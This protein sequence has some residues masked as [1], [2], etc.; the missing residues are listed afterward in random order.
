MKKIE[1]TI[2]LTGAAQAEYIRQRW[3]A[4]VVTEQPTLYTRGNVHGYTE[5]LELIEAA[6]DTLEPDVKA[7]RE[8]LEVFI[9][10]ADLL[11]SQEFGNI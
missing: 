8:A 4:V 2:A 10:N 5:L 1:R 9:A 11:G 3:P 7:L 6:N